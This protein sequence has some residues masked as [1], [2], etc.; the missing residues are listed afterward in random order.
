MPKDM[1]AR[2]RRGLRTVAAFYAIAIGLCFCLAITA[3]LFGASET[4]AGGIAFIAWPATVLAMW[5]SRFF[6]ASGRQHPEQT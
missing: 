3:L 5:L 1:M 6:R 4:Q 2:G